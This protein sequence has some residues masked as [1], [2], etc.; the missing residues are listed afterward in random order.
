[1][2]TCHMQR[3]MLFRSRRFVSSKRTSNCF[4]LLPTSLQVFYELN[5]HFL[6]PYNFQVPQSEYLNS[7]HNP[8]PKE[9]RGLNLGRILRNFVHASNTE[10]SMKIQSVRMKLDGIGFP[11]LRDWNQFQWEEVTLPALKTYKQIIG[12]LSVPRKFIVP[13]RDQQW[14]NATWGLKLGAHVNTLRQSREKLTVQQ[15]QDL[16]DIGFIWTVADY[17]WN[18]LF[19]P[20]LQHYRKLYGHSQ[21]PQHFVVEADKESKWP[22]HL[23][24]YRLG[25]VINS[26]RSSL[27]LTDYVRQN[28][29][30]LEKM[31]FYLRS[32]DHR[33]QKVILPA[34]Q[35]YYQVYRNCNVK[36]DFVVPEK[37]PWPLSVRGINL[38]MIA[39]NIRY[40]GDYFLQVA[41][42]YETLEKIGFV[43]SAAAF[44][45]QYVVL[46]ALN[47]YVHLFGN[48][49]VP[50]DFVVPS[51]N[52]WPERSHGFKLGAFV[53][54]PK[55]RERFTD[56]IEIDRLHLEELGFFWS[57][58]TL[59]N[60]KDNGG[61]EFL[62][63]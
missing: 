44:K 42:D 25:K 20:A 49:H 39:Q 27:A 45:W 46:P 19:M 2:T 33:W 18:D 54:C 58:F 51:N 52:Q 48:A 12:N 55:R 6:V 28:R 5:G 47:T 8:W 13:E 16:A 26:I 21:V 59:D 9:T 35:T 7:T 50:T 34:F 43:W 56:Y 41:R 53:T 31:G 57:S 30:E 40:R 63:E 15:V 17:K 23:I 1:M 11:K 36:R 22:T 10:R 62:I 24:G 60:C 38:G 4:A 37:E 32:T 14:P 29:I 61:I 3:Q